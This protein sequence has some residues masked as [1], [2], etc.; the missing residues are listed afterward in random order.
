MTVA[1][2]LGRSAETVRFGVRE[3]HAENPPHIVFTV[4]IP[5]A[6]LQALFITLLGGVIGGPELR[7]YAFV[8][9]LAVILPLAGVI[10]VGEI[11]GNDKWNGTFYRVRSGRMHPFVI[12]FLR[13]LP[14]VLL[15]V[16]FSA[17]ALLVVG[18]LTGMGGLALRLVPLLPLYVLMSATVTAAGLAAAA[19][20]VGRRADV[21]IGNLVSYLILF[22]G[23]VLVPPGRLAVADVVG[24]VLPV[25]HGLQ[26]VHA[27][28]AG[29]PWLGHAALECGVGA[30]WAAVALLVVTLQVRRAH[31]HGHDDFA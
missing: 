17:A 19:F 31:R 14:Y 4:L 16:V 10:A 25:R 7:E 2:Q 12:F 5:R 22:A 3:F 15:G 29:E 9:S 13:A 20:A 24:A 23:G 18:A 27:A 11:P 1:D 30:G 28:L 8:G 6:V 21:L 26:A